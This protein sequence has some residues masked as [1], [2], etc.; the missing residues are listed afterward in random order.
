MQR[1]KYTAR[2]Y[3]PKQ[4]DW[5]VWYAG[6]EG[7]MGGVQVTEDKLYLFLEVQVVNRES[8]ASGYQTRTVKCKEMWKDGGR[9]KKRV[10]DG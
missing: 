7:N 4:E 3:E 10:E 5:K 9:A 2:T 6:L 8:R 1:P